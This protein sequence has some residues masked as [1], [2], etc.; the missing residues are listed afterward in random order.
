MTQ[1]AVSFMFLAAKYW[2]KESEEN[3]ETKTPLKKVKQCTQFC[4]FVRQNCTVKALRAKVFYFNWIF[5]SSKTKICWFFLSTGIKSVKF[6]HWS[7]DII[8][9]YAFKG[10]NHFRFIAKPRC[11]PPKLWCYFYCEWKRLSSSRVLCFRF[12]INN[13]L[14]FSDLWPK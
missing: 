10:W 13:N 6:Y 3:G 5:F 12:P 11:Y 1:L 2:S 8:E 7:Y 14:H 4:W 9:V